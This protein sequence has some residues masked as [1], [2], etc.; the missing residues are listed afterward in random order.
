[1]PFLVIM[2]LVVTFLVAGIGLRKSFSKQD[3]SSQ[4]TSQKIIASS[5][6]EIEDMLMQIDR[7][8]APE[9]KMGAMCY[10]IAPPSEY[11]EYICPIDGE[12]TVYNTLKDSTAYWI[13][14]NIVEMR[15]L[16]KQLNSETKL[17][18]FELDERRL[19]HTCFPNISK[20]ELYVSLVTKYPDGKQYSY[21]NVSTEDLRILIGFFGNKLSYESERDAEYSL[22][23]QTDK[24]KKLLGLDKLPID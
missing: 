20:D 12:K 17:A 24:I 1:M 15:R 3:V 9:E 6:G 23:K 10:D 18:E 8:D 14:E 11:L 4:V 21:D 2:I 7:K 19:C 5:H 16:I 22:K 13:A